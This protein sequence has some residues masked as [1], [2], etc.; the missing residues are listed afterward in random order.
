V[1]ETKQ[2]EQRPGQGEQE[3]EDQGLGMGEQEPGPGGARTGQGTLG[4]IQGEQGRKGTGE[5]G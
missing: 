2:G 5:Q 1:V 4:L 3:Q